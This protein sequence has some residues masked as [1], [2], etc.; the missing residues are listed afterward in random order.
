MYFVIEKF[1]IHNTSGVILKVA[2]GLDD[3]RETI[4]DIMS[5]TAKTLGMTGSIHYDPNFNEFYGELENERGVL[6]YR[7]RPQYRDEDLSEYL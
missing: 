4:N 7:A 2:S 3:A 6:E 5:R 1:S